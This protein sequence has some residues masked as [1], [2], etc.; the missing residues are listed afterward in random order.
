MHLQAWLMRD[1][2]FSPICHHFATPV[3]GGSMGSG[4]EKFENC[5]CEKGGEEAVECEAE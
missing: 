2:G 3:S 1:I 4:S 5:R